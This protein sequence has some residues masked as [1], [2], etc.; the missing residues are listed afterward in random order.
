MKRHGQLMTAI[1]EP[2]NL[3]LAFW[4][5]AK[6]KRDR[7]DCRAFQKNLDDTVASLRS[8]LLSGTVEVGDCHTF[9]IQD[10]HLRRA[11]PAAGHGGRP[12][13]ILH[14]E[15]PERVLPI[16]HKFL[17]HRQH[18]MPAQ[19]AVHLGFRLADILDRY[20]KQFQ[21]HFVSIPRA[22][23]EEF[24]TRYAGFFSN[25][26]VHVTAPQSVSLAAPR[27]LR[28]CSVLLMADLGPEQPGN[29]YC[30]W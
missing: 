12:V 25:S 4:K 30:C 21:L 7:A 3:R 1:A 17:L 8:E 2:A 23:A 5:A 26:V 16:R 28:C 24:P 15:R 9:T 6:S 14:A 13:Q 29:R 20:H 18:P 22:F 10:P 27:L 19:K 11:P